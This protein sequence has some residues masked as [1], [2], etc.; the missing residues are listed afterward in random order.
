MKTVPLSVLMEALAALEKTHNYFNDSPVD[1]QPYIE[2]LRAKSEL[3][4][5]ISKITEQT[6]VGVV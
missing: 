2:V 4:W 6:K 5:Y 1:G 3:G